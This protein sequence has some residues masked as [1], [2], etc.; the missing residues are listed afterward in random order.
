MSRILWYLFS[1]SLFSNQGKAPMC[2]HRGL[3]CISMGGN[4]PIKT[5]PEQDVPG[6][7]K[8]GKDRAAPGTVLN[9]GDQTDST[10]AGAD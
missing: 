8:Q 10:D 6:D 1:T 4:K 7:A 2:E 3:F 5:V 9:A